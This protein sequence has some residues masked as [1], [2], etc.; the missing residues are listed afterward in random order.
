MVAKPIPKQIQTYLDVP[1]F[2]NPLHLD[3]LMKFAGGVPAGK[4]VLEIGCAFGC[5]TWALLDSL[6]DGCELHVCD[7][8]GMTNINLRRK[9][10]QGVME[11]H[12]H[13]SAVAYAMHTYLED[14]SVNAQRNVFD[15]VVAQHP[16]RHKILKQVHQQ[17]SLELLANDTDWGMVY[18]DGLHSY[19]NVLA[20]LLNLEHV[21]LL[22]GDD[23]HPAHPGTMQAIDEFME[24]HKNRRNFTHDPFDT[25]SG[26]WKMTL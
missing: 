6:S 9:H 24:K 2:N 18:I 21:P 1:G 22:C 5:S 14:E 20:E 25:G 15:W 3:N 12:Q 13:N 10:F 19:E 11:K 17:R 8:F 4:R 7:T 23:Y 26:F 16:R